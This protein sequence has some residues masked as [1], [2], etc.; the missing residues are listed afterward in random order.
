VIGLLVA[1]GPA[2]AERTLDWER[3]D[4]QMTLHRD[5]SIDVVETMRVRLTGDWNG[6]YRELSLAGCDGIEI[7]GVSEDG[8]GYASGSV[9]SVAKR[10]QIE[11]G[12]GTVLARWRSRA[13][14][15]PEYCD[16]AIAFSVAY[17]IIG[18]IGQ[19][20]RRDV[21]HWRPISD[22][23]DAVLP[24]VAITLKLPAA[25][26]SAEVRFH[27]EAP[28]AAWEMLGDAVRFTASNVPPGDHCEIEVALPKGMLDEYNSFTNTYYHNVKPWVLPGGLATIVA[29][30]ALV[31]MLAG[32][33][34]EPGARQ[35]QDA[36]PLA[37]PPAL[38]GLLIDERIQAH[39]LLASLLD[40]AD[41]GIIR[42]EQLD[43]DEHAI[44]LLRAPESGEELI[45]LE[46]ALLDGLLGP[47]AAPGASVRT[48]MLRIRFH[49]AVPA[50]RR[51]AWGEAERR[52][53]FDV[54]PRRS[55][56]AGLIIGLVAIAG[57]AILAATERPE[58]AFFAVWGS[59]FSGIPLASILSAVRQRGWRGLLGVLPMFLFVGVGAAVIGLMVYRAYLHGSWRVDVGAVLALAGAAIAAS[60]P[61]FGRKS[62]P[63]AALTEKLR[64]LRN[65]LRETPGA[66]AADLGAILPWAVA[67]GT[68]E[69]TI[70]LLASGAAGGETVSVP[71]YTTHSAAPSSASSASGG[72]SAID[73]GSVTR[74]LAAMT[75][76]IRSAMAP[77]P[78]R[79][80]RSGGGSSGGGSSG[81]GGGG[82]GGGRAG[83]W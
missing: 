82:G 51:E 55:R 60:G 16:E 18:S 3:I 40:L 22:E 81:G 32:R 47:G 33:D 1:T 71:W 44:A 83:G 21:L 63:G 17:R 31:W 13:P 59:L 80:G 42:I 9:S 10:Y 57:G 79:S 61:A 56:R 70:S 24:A 68:A 74:G 72:A 19:H 48:D 15:D 43:G 49:C 75:S 25:P 7:L 6:L 11:H 34:P 52:G 64:E 50:L 35:L 28:S 2:R 53:W 62:L 30:L 46:R 29:A 73:V 77:A 41:R 54:D 5:T 67:L 23:R 14:D 26:D 58:L 27:S 37:I 36:D 39:D 78:A 76:S 4:V 65:L 12:D 66:V 38:A 45:P 8:V 69:R 20:V